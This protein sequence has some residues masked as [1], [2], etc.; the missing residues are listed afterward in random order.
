[1][2]SII[3]ATRAIVA[4]RDKATS[5][6]TILAFALPHAVLLAVLGGLFAFIDRA[7]SPI[8]MAMGEEAYVPL[9]AFATVLLVVP[10]ASMGAAAARLGLSR[11]AQDLA[12]LRL[13]GVSGVTARAACVVDTCLHAVVGVIAGSVIYAATLPIWSL[14]TFQEMPLSASEMWTGPLV[15]LGAAGAMIL[16]SAASSWMGMR[17][18]AITP[19]GVARRSEAQHIKPWGVLIALI[20]GVVWLA[21]GAQL[22]GLGRTIGTGILLGFTALMI[23]LVN[24]VGTWSLS[25]I[26]RI[27]ARFA[28]SPQML[29]AGRRLADDPKSVWRSYGSIPVVGFIAGIL[30]PVMTVLAVQTSQLQ[31]GDEIPKE[32]LIFSRDI[33]TGIALTLAITFV[34]AAIATAVNQSIRAVDSASQCKALLRAGA[35][36]TFLARS[37]RIEVGIPAL[38]LIGGSMGA[39]I[40]FMIP[41]ITSPGMLSAL[42]STVGLAIAGTLLVLV[43]SEVAAPV[44]KQAIRRLGS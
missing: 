27:M 44:G 21:A 35:K 23:A 26:G 10:A 25:V 4:S 15:L 36:P 14:I 31:A 38:L 41:A 30:Y 18:V 11:R 2:N 3:V 29:L 40:A 19:L 5:V 34:L 16:L 6:L 8:N 13:V 37:R 24:A 28:R 33:G 9:A 32:V 39:G 17:K 43:A 7:A 12:V 1:M 20:L 42:A 22:L